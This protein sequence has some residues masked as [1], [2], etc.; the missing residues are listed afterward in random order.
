MS[1]T[2]TIGMLLLDTTP[3]ALKAREE[4]AAAVGGAEIGEPDEGG[5]FDLTL[6]ADSQDDALQRVWDGVAKAGADDHIA[7]AEHPSLP[8]HWRRRARPGG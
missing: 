6:V 3:R 7:F 4:L 8:D 2:F 5:T 1:E